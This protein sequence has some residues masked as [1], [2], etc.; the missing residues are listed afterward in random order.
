MRTEER[1]ALWKHPNAFILLD[2]IAYRASRKDNPVRGLKCG[3]AWIGDYENY[4]MSESTY[5]W[6]KK[7]LQEF[8]L[9]TFRTTN[10]GTTARLLSTNVYDINEE[11][12]DGQHNTQSDNASR[13]R[14]NGCDRNGKAND[15]QHNTPTTGKNRRTRGGATTKC[16]NHDGQ[17]NT[18][19][20]NASR[21]RVNGCDRNGK[22]NN[23]QHN[24]P[25]TGQRRANDGPTT[26]NKKIR[27]KEDKKLS[28][29]ESESGGGFVSS[30]DSCLRLLVALRNTNKLPALEREHL[31][32]LNMDFPKADLFS[33]DTMNRLVEE[34]RGV[35]G[36][37]VADTAAW[38]RKKVSQIEVMRLEQSGEGV[39]R[40]AWRGRSGDQGSRVDGPVPFKGIGPD[41]P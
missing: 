13:S 5:R 34:A 28:L 8:K 37:V 24:R 41:S 26:T 31:I 18:Q 19:S 29:S 35:A 21:S 25:T 30:G 16:E 2:V 32:R 15:G 33:S 9:A 6:A 11:P 38:L 12:N 4:G 20:D 1:E 10:K 7:K 3:E 36:S 22:A 14:V 40:K 17:H 27:S 39:N 23:G